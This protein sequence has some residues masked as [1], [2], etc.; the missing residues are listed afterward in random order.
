[1]TTSESEARPLEGSC[2]AKVR[3]TPAGEIELALVQRDDRSCA[4]G[5][6]EIAWYPDRL[7]VT[8]L[9]AGSASITNAYLSGEAAQDVTLEI[10]LPSLDELTETVPGA[11]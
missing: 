11:D 3:S 10:R 7:K 6:V 8:V 2:I 9:G 4:F 5:P 1:M